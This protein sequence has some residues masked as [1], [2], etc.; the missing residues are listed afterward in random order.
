M[1]AKTFIIEGPSGCGKSLT[2]WSYVNSVISGDIVVKWYNCA[3]HQLLTM[4]TSGITR[5]C[6][7]DIH[8][9]NIEQFKSTVLV[10]DS[11]ATDSWKQVLKVVQQLVE[12]EAM[13]IILIMS[14]SKPSSSVITMLDEFA[15][16][17]VTHFLP[18]WSLEDCLK[19]CSEYDFFASIF[20]RLTDKDHIRSMEKCFNDNLVR[21]RLVAR[22]F[23]V[24][25]GSASFMFDYTFT[26]VHS[27][28]H[29]HQV[30]KMNHANST[31][32][33]LILNILKALGPTILRDQLAIICWIFLTVRHLSSIDIK[34]TIEEVK[35]KILRLFLML[36]CTFTDK[37]K[38]KNTWSLALLFVV[39]YSL[40]GSRTKTFRPNHD[41]IQSLFKLLDDEIDD[42]HDWLMTQE[43]DFTIVSV[44][45]ECIGG[46]HVIPDLKVV[47]SLWQ[48]VS[49]LITSPPTTAPV[50][51][52]PTE[53][54]E[55]EAKSEE[56]VV[57]SAANISGRAGSNRLISVPVINSS[58]RFPT[59]F[60]S[61]TSI[62]V[63][64]PKKILEGG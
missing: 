6:E 4:K 49:T 27:R 34:E 46:I 18:Q 41:L 30:E 29:R 36:L 15:I 59:I 20:D 33:T 25:D 37:R 9:N 55:D 12:Q 11:V 62:R 14:S 26:K 31:D 3:N 42:F 61:A 17:G 52:E 43:E 63:I 5:E 32:Y 39:I 8:C 21:N 16:R 24:C 7:I 53:S 47:T 2:V 22:K 60:S 38:W 50:M 54:I 57:T 58:W 40:I 56:R 10:I 35:E 48:Q 1:I 13:Y 19:A 44:Y 64:E 28:F 23:N 51:V 45:N